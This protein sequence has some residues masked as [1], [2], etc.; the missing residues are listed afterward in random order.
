M[1]ICS[2]CT[3]ASG[4]AWVCNVTD[5]HNGTHH[6]SQNDNPVDRIV[7]DRTDLLYAAAG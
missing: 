3:Q 7:E 2:D 5:R 6:R 1:F 4:Q